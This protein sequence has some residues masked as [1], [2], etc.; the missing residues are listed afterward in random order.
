MEKEIGHASIAGKKRGGRPKK[1][2]K[3]SEVLKVRLTRAERMIIE[4]RAEKAGVNT[5]EWFRQAARTGRVVARF[6]P[7]EMGWLRGLSGLCNNLNQL[8]KLAHSQGLITLTGDLRALLTKIN[9]VIEKLM[10]DDR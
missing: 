9:V 6:S 5:S 10:D 8:T 1:E 2:I 4:N 7:E 3:R